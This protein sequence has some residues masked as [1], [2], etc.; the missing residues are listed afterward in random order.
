MAYKAMAILDR[1]SIM[2]IATLRPDGWPQATTVGYVNEGMMLYFLISRT[3]QKFK[4]ITA[5]DRVSIAIA[6]EAALPSQIEGL[7]MSATVSESRD[8]P[9]RSQILSKLS[10]RHP[11]YFDP[12]TLDMTKSALFRASPEIISVVDFSKGLGHAETVTVGAEQIVE[13]TANRP[14]NWGPNPSH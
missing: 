1:H 13:M 9:Y 6:S 14:N 11:G 7:S 3:S 5:D 12:K 10:A 2:T 8:E 4:N